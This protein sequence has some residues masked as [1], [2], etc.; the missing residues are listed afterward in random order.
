[1]PRLEQRCGPVPPRTI[2]ADSPTAPAALELL[3]LWLA[4]A[5]P[6]GDDEKF[7]ALR[8][9]AT[10]ARLE[11][12]VASLGEQRMQGMTL[13]MRGHWRR[14]FVHS[15]NNLYSTVRGET[16]GMLYRF[17][18]VRTMA[19]AVVLAAL[20]VWHV[21]SFILTVSSLWLTGAQQ[22]LEA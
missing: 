6:L 14:D 18:N 3:S 12:C 4:S 13:N 19:G 17:A 8:G 9:K 21:P 10:L 16:R 20:L 1:M 22:S 7:A 2:N 11:T 15:L 5:C